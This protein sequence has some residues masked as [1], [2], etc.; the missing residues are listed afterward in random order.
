MAGGDR[1][2]GQNK[3]KPTNVAY[4]AQ[5]RADRNRKLRAARLVRIGRQHTEKRQAVAVKR[6]RGA[7]I[8]LERR[9]SAGAA[10]L[11]GSL[12]KAKDAFLRAGGAA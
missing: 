1:K 10:G 5:G 8:R 12:A 3:R 4:K 2:I 6:K 7:V 11:S 9:I